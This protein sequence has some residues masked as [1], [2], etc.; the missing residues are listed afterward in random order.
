MTVSTYI[1]FFKFFD[2]I[3]MPKI[4][5]NIIETIGQNTIIIY[6]FSWIIGYTVFPIILAKLNITSN[7]FYNFFKAFIQVLIL[8]YLGKYLKK[9]PLLKKIL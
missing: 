1:I 4:I 9:V 3:K 7:L 6:Y 5:V 2:N 8:G